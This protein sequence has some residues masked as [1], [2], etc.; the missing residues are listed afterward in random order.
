MTPSN[1]SEVKALKQHLK[2]A[3]M[4]KLT[5]AQQALRRAR[6]EA[7]AANK[8]AANVKAKAKAKPTPTGRPGAVARRSR[9]GRRGLVAESSGTDAKR[10]RV[11]DADPSVDGAT[12]PSA[13]GAPLR[14]DA[15]PP[16]SLLVEP[17]LEAGPAGAGP[18]VALDLSRVCTT[19]E[20]ILRLLP[21]DGACSLTMDQAFLRWRFKVRGEAPPFD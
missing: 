1:F 8:K 19:P 18:S 7:A 3:Q 21:Q 4:Q 5:Q 12:D 10:P 13:F 6:A 2:R 15:T 16:P 14:P 20:L 9:A 17:G 11:A